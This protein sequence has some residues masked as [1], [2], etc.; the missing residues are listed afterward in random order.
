MVVDF[1]NQIVEIMHRNFDPDV[2]DSLDGLIRA[3]NRAYRV[4]L[5]ER[6]LELTP[7]ETQA[8]RFLERQPGARL[9]HLVAE[10]GRDKAQITRTMRTLE[11]QG[12]V[13]RVPDPDDQRCHRLHLSEDGHET[14]LTLQE[15]R[16]GIEAQLFA[17]LGTG[18]QRRLATLLRRCLATLQSADHAAD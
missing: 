14:C 4:R 3:I 1:V 8:L 15:I 7:P 12:L 11:D 13:E 9:H 16:T 2:A 5:N 6:G 18:E 10:T 17:G